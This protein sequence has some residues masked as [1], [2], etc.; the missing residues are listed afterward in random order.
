M[1]QQNRIQS[2]IED[3]GGSVFVALDEDKVVGTAAYRV[4]IGTEWYRRGKYAYICFGSVLP[5]YT[6]MGVLRAM[7]KERDKS[8]EN[9][10]LS[11]SYFDTNIR[12]ARRISI[13]R[14]E[15][16]RLV[17]VEYYRDHYSV[18]LAKWASVGHSSIYCH[19]H[20]VVAMVKASIKRIVSVFRGE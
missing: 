18:R 7:N 12:N 2:Y 8:I 15:G 5:A 6:G 17:D 3:G 9:H 4:Q 14:K 16:Y 1:P 20:F 19:F 11:T 10:G 13:A